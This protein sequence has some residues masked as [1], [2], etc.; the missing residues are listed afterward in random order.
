MN[1]LLIPLFIIIAL[2]VGYFVGTVIGE[3]LSPGI[4]FNLIFP[5]NNTHTNGTNDSIKFRFSFEDNITNNNLTCQLKINEVWIAINA[6]VQNATATNISA[7]ITLTDGVKYWNIT[8]SNQTN[9][10]NVTATR[11]LYLDNAAPVIYATTYKNNTNSANITINTTARDAGILNCTAK[12]NGIGIEINGTLSS[13]NLTDYYCFVTI[14]ATHVSDIE[15]QFNVSVSIGDYVG[16]VR[17]INY[18]N[19]T[20][21]TLYL[22]WNLIQADRKGTLFS[23][24]FTSNITRVS[25]YNNSGQS[26]G[27]SWKNY[28]VGVAANNATPV[29]DGDGLFVYATGTTPLLRIWTVDSFPRNMTVWKSWNLMSH[30][31]NSAVKLLNLSNYELNSITAENLTSGYQRIDY[32]VKYNASNQFHYVFRRGMSINNETTVPRGEAFWVNV[33]GTNLTMAS[34][35]TLWRDPV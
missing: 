12:I 20:K 35:I 29:L 6:T 17:N 28:V 25:W 24:N 26:G 31:N 21:N 10:F 34:N 14:N 9:A 30:Y 32:V 27:K 3:G 13:K 16:F 11:I 5:P 15:G 33:N 18:T 2:V 23:Y 1:K 22:G 8:C 4:S 7:N 19:F